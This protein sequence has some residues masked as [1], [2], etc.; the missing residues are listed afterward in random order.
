MKKI[1]FSILFIA[2]TSFAVEYGVFM[3]VKG[4]VSIENAKETVDAKVNS[5]IQ[6]G[7][8]VVT[9]KDSR[10]KI[11]MTDRNI[12]NISPDTRLK[13]EKYT[14]SAD[15]KNVKLNLIEGKVR[16]NVEQKYDNETTRFEV[17]TATAVAGVRGTQFITSYDKATKIT[18]VVTITGHIHFKSTGMVG[19][20]V[21]EK[22]EKSQ[23]QDGGIAA[24]P[25]KIPDKEFQQI[26]SETAIK[27]KQP[28]KA[29]VGNSPPV[30]AIVDRNGDKLPPPPGTHLEDM[31]RTDPLIKDGTTIRRFEKSKV[32]VITQPSP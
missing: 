32:N 4:K 8:T 19:P 22:G 9:A 5:K 24:P 31:R 10:A 21:V 7:D 27:A 15:D 28:D 1:L 14:N 2:Q 26:D 11:V 6:V 18:E 16:N 30:P 20:I 13:I 23:A 12:I 3:V 25:V 29:V 17:R